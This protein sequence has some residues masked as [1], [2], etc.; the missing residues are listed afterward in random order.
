M[1]PVQGSDIAATA[2]EAKSYEPE[3]RKDLA[4]CRPQDSLSVCRL[5]TSTTSN[6]GNRRFWSR[7]GQRGRYSE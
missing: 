4:T 1:A 7:G 2:D 5:A 3:S 6:S